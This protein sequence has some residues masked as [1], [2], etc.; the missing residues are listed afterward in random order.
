MDNIDYSTYP[1]HPDISYPY[2]VPVMGC[3]YLFGIDWAYLCVKLCDSY[4][5]M[6]KERRN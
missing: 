2:Y 6:W 3:F 1:I 4:G 5:V